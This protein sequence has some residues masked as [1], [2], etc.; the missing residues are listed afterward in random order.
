[1]IT[2]AFDWKPV[3]HQADGLEATAFGFLDC[4]AS[5]TGEWKVILAATVLV[6]W[7][8]QAK[9]KDINEA[10]QRAQAAAIVHLQLLC[11]N[12]HQHHA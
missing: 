5:A 12:N 1:M 3:P 2:E 8:D 4:H 10:K 9:G 7:K 6:C 11:T